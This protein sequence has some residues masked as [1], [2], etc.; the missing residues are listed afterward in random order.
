MKTVFLIHGYNGI[1]PIFKWLK[2]ELIK[3]EYEV[4][5]PEFPNGEKINFN[6]WIKTL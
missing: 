2:E 6:L 3:K 1:P 4:I 5:I